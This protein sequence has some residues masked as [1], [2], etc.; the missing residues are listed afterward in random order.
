VK[1]GGGS[2]QPA[3]GLE[4]TEE[5]EQKGRLGFGT[6]QPWQGDVCNAVVSSVSSDAARPSHSP[7]VESVKGKFRLDC[8]NA[9]SFLNARGRA[10]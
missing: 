2:Y 10:R 4:G 1:G 8:L 3:N 5:A 6:W 7:F 9:P